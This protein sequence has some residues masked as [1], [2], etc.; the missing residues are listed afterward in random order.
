MIRVLKVILKAAVRLLLMLLVVWLACSRPL[1]SLP[2]RK[3]RTV[4]ISEDALRSHVHKLSAELVPRD[5][6]HT[7]NLKKVAE[8]IAGVF[9]ETSDRVRMEP[10]SI[11]NK[12]YY[13]VV[14]EYGPETGSPVIIGAHY[15]AA[16]EFP[17]ADDNA[18]GIAGVLELARAFRTS[19]PA[20]RVWLAAF[21]LEEP[22]FFETARMG[23]RIFARSLRKSGTDVRLMIAFEMIGY[24]SSRP[25]SQKY[26]VPFL[27]FY[28]PS[29]GDFAAIIGDFDFSGSAVAIRRA[30]LEST[31]LSVFSLNA[32]SFLPAVSFSDQGSFWAEGFSAVMIT[33]TAF[34][35]N[36]AYHGPGDTED[37]LDYKRMAEVVKGTAAYVLALQ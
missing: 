25:S 35:R 7:E 13:N 20:V 17:G 10:F 5:W 27:S 37:R 34:L 21:T 16:G 23:S 19:K 32:P 22:P 26:Y 31:D 1:I 12:E 33:D 8:Y 3:D 9:R 6:K 24:F 14:A 30:F 18:S 11:D 29:I 4:R 36:F 2:E 28:Y 15:D